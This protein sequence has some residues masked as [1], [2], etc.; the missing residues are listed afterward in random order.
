MRVELSIVMG[1]LGHISHG[2]DPVGRS[3]TSLPTVAEATDTGDQRRARRVRGRAAVV[4]ALI[5]VLEDGGPIPN[6]ST[7]AEL[8]GVSSAS[9]FRYFDSIDE[10][11]RE[12]ALEHF[13]RNERHFGIPDIGVGQLEDRVTGFVE[14]RA[15]LYRRTE[16]VARFGRARSLEVPFFAEALRR[17]RLDQ[18]AQIHVHFA[19]ELRRLD[20]GAAEDLASNIATLTSFESWELQHHDFGRDDEAVMR[21]WSDGIHAMLDQI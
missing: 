12:A 8:A 2:H 14:A 20:P 10:L 6:A 9:L 15:K 21:S 4:D 17:V 1:A 18:L 5:G 7:I 3:T 16:R 11:Q 19:Q 13:K